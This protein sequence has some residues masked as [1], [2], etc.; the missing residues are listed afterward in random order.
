MIK[1]KKGLDLPIEGA[2]VQK[3]Y[4]GPKVNTVALIGDDYVG[5][6]PSMLVQ[7]GDKVTIGQKLFSDKKTLGVDYT[8]PA[9]GEVIAINRGEKRVFQSMVIRVEGEKYQNFSSFKGSNF[10]KLSAEQVKELMLESGMWAALRMRPYSKVAD[11]ATQASSIFVTAMDTRPLAA[12]PEIVINENSAAFIDGLKVL[13]ILNSKLFLCTQAGSKIPGSD[14]ASLHEFAGPH[15]AGNVGTHIHY[16]DPVGTKKQVW[17]MDYQDVIALGML[18]TT[19]KLYTEK[20]VSLAGPIVKKPR[21]VKTKLGANLH[22]LVEGENF[23]VTEKRII[24]GSVFGGRKVT[25]NKEF[26]GRYHNQV[27]LLK[28]GREREF[29]G[30]HSPGFNKFSVKNIYLSKLL[31]KK[32]PFTTTTSGSLRSIVPIGSYEKVMPLDIHATFL[33]RALMSGNNEMLV[34]LGGLE[35]DEEDL[36]LCAFVDPCKN[37]FGPELRKRLVEIEKDG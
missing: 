11:P 10:E 14:I 15:P 35:L 4:E 3:I 25:E 20:V 32:F 23:E 19:G 2:P 6:K 29:F 22:D 13:K 34:K 31:P 24:S 9:S 17:H 8:S 21:L 12:N 37:E 30:W 5:M 16:L 33:L 1:I 18:F 7:V 28:E 27:T 36:A 26:L